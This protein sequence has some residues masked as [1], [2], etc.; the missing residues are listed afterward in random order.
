MMNSA[1][2]DGTSLKKPEFALQNVHVVSES[3]SKQRFCWCMPV[4]ISFL[5]MLLLGVTSVVMGAA[6]IKTQ[7]SIAPPI[8]L[9][10]PES[11]IETCESLM[12]ASQHEIS[13]HPDN[14][15]L[16]YWMNNIVKPILIEVGALALF[17]SMGALPMLTK[18]FLSSRRS[19]KLLRLVA[20][21]KVATRLFRVKWRSPRMVR[22]IHDSAK[23]MYRSRS[24]LSAASD[25]T[26]V[27][28]DDTE[29]NQTK[30]KTQDNTIMM[31]AP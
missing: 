16:H 20:T 31:V 18:L 23:R 4:A 11:T 10:L 8:M 5:L 25:I 19:S 26:H 24:R 22:R 2:L 21:K 15:N 27:I 13:T 28:G 1:F 12:L 30:P 9:L 17:Q 14:D 29:S 7:S 6:E 3:S